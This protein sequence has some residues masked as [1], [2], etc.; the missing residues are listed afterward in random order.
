MSNNPHKS[1]PG[2]QLDAAS[3]KSLEIQASYTP[4]NINHVGGGGG[5]S[6]GCGQGVGIWQILR[7]FD[8]ISKGGK[9]KV[10]QKCQ[11]SPYPRKI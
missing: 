7:F 9:R 5:V 4:I 8:Q 2:R 6:A 11:K 1:F 10:N 3:S